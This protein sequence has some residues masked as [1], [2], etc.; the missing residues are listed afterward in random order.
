M[1]S[2]GP[3]TGESPVFNSREVFHV[4]VPK[5]RRHKKNYARVL[6][7]DRKVHHGVYGSTESKGKLRT[8]CFGM[9][10]VG[11]QGTQAQTCS[12]SKKLNED[13]G[14]GI[15][16]ITEQCFQSFV[17][18]KSYFIKAGKPTSEVNGIPL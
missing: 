16:T 12:Y 11:P 14:D 6:L 9:A 4:K 10:S 3:K 8:G 13:E 15:L 7:N 18:A 5:Y 1:P 17:F 2:L